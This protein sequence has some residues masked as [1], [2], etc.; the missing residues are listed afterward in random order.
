MFSF[1]LIL[2]FHYFLIRQEAIQNKQI[3]NLF[4]I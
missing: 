4:L 2:A 3:K 1:D